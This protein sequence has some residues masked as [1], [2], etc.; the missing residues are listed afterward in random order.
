[1]KYD[2][3]I[4]IN[5]PIQLV[6]ELF[7]DPENLKHYQDGFVKKVH[8]SGTPGAEGAVSELHYSH[9]GRDMV[10]KETIGKSN[11]PFRFE[12]TYSHPMMD[13]TLKTT[14]TAIS[15]DQTLYKIEV[16]YTAIN[17]IVP[18]LMALFFPGM[19]T[20]QGKTWMA[21]FKRFVEAQ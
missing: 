6:A 18:N 15:I 20:K 3:S 21:N 9:K 2:G 10:L 17:G 12:A 1:M 14:F 8:V 5:K 13:N 7:T 4:Q 19:F 11:P 16:E